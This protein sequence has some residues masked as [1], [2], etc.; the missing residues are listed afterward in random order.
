MED[1]RIDGVP[2]S[3]EERAGLAVRE[4]AEEIAAEAAAEE[5][6]AAPED[7]RTDFQ[8]RCAAISDKKWNIIQSIGG[9]IL[10]GAVVF[11][12][13]GGTS[14]DAFSIFTVYALVLAMF[15]PKY[16]E[17]TCDRNLDRG[18]I[19]MV[20]AIAVGMILQLVIRGAQNGFALH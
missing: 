16:V 5:E 6:T 10:G 3:Q 19:V 13:F 20:I 18:R 12:L 17:K 15:V 1:K 7:T 11:F 14:D 4:Q 8:R 9:V 2:E